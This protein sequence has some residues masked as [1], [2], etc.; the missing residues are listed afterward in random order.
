MNWK[1]V[2]EWCLGANDRFGTCAYAMVGN[3]RIMLGSAVMPDGEIENAA[4]AIEGFNPYIAATD[5]GENL[6][7]LFDYIEQNGWPG[8]FTLKISQWSKIALSQLAETIARRSAAP[9]WLMLPMNEA[10]DDYDFSEDA[11]FRGAV[12]VDAH[13]VCVVEADSRNV[14]FITWARPVTVSLSWAQR[15][16]RGSYDVEWTDLA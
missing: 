12:G 11:I 10:G 14:T 15:Y 13:A 8:D 5:R 9:T 16:F 1:D 7:A 3:H 4:R 6:E 2:T